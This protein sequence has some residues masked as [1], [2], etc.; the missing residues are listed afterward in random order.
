MVLQWLDLVCGP[1]SALGPP[2]SYPEWLSSASAVPA[3]IFLAT[4]VSLW[5][6]ERLDLSDCLSDTHF[7]FGYAGRLSRAFTCFLR[8]TCFNSHDPHNDFAQNLI[9]SFF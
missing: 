3:G 5:T 2:H 9:S 6:W 7:D 4:S 1:S 8:K